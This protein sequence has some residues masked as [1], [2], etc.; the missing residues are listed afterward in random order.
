M[1]TLAMEKISQFKNIV[2]EVIP[3]DVLVV[4]VARVV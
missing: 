4:L 2:N 1:L 3:S